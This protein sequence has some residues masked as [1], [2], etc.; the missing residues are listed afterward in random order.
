MIR[1]SLVL[2]LLASSIL[3]QA[4]LA[5]VPTKV[6]V[7]AAVNQQVTGTPP[8]SPSRTVEIGN[9]V[10]HRERLVTNAQGQAQMLFVD[11]SA[12]TV[13]PDSDLVLDEFVYDP[14]TGTGKLAATA[15]KGLVRFVGG[16]L[17]KSQ[18]VTITTPTATIGIRGGIA[19]V[20]IDES[21]GATQATF[22]F[23]HE[24]TVTSANGA[25][26]RIA[27]A[28]FTT[29]VQ[30][31]A[32]APT[33]AIKASGDQLKQSLDQ[34][35]GRSDAS[36][37]AAQQPTNNQVATRIQPQ[38]QGQQPPPPQGGPRPQG[39]GAG[40]TLPPTGQNRDGIEASRRT[41]LNNAGLPV[42]AVVAYRVDPD[43][44]L[45]SSL[46]SVRGAATGG[47]SGTAS[48][49]YAVSSGTTGTV[50]SVQVSVAIEGQGASQRSV[51]A[52]TTGEGGEAGA[53]RAS[54]RGTSRT[55]P[56]VEGTTGIAAES[57]LSGTGS[58]V[59]FAAGR[60]PDGFVQTGS[61]TE[62]PA[63]AT[64]TNSYGFR[65]NGVRLQNPPSVGARQSE[66]LLGY[67]T[68]MGDGTRADGRRDPTYTMIAGAGG[69]AAVQPG[70]VVINTDAASGRLAATFRLTEDTA[71][72][73]AP[74][75]AAKADVVLNFGADPGKG[76][77]VDKTRFAA[78][79]SSTAVTITNDRGTKTA[80]KNSLYL[81]SSGLASA[82]PS[83]VTAC[84]CEFAQWGYW[85]AVIVSTA[86][87]GTKRTDQMHMG[88][89]VAGSMVN[90]SDMPTTGS[91]SYSG[92]AVGTVANNGQRYVA[93]GAFAA[94][95]DFGRR[96]GNM[97]ISNFDGLT[98]SGVIASTNGR[99]YSSTLSINGR[100]DLAGKA[101]G[102]FFG[103]QT[104]PARETGG[105]FTVANKAGSTT[106][107]AATGI[108]VGRKQ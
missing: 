23:G 52:V 71:P 40:Q 34:L 84:A 108:F 33:A 27:R 20:S 11:G 93:G 72:G 107:Y 21:S 28:G 55:N 13:G 98:M 99:D 15:A 37:G 67:A 82:L 1:S 10:F 42:G 95:F 14:T 32:A 7:A 22:L 76:T 104:D 3:S 68:G 101:Q 54:T 18:P 63:G 35:N 17:S 49:L 70:N 57:T 51:V 92:H 9:D 75:T 26:E 25:I 103:A 97:T 65:Q 41:A 59:N 4:S 19:I 73:A 90:A 29:T 86:D 44:Q 74:G 47:A 50:K 100:N 96:Q 105:Q 12:F 46:P 64:T 60:V 78:V 24:M 6:G 38:S 85:G 30:S 66:A 43:T 48:S 53:M 77:Y 5:Q 87:D 69:A 62:L 16:K 8:A 88:T 94:Q 89:W 58:I 79:E 31:L 39:Q 80:E 2:A 102:S 56:T 91:A 45:S 61:G 106:N 81:V 36:G 83:G